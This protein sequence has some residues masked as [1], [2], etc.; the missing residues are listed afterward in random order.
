MEGQAEAP[1]SL[2]EGAPHV[3]RIVRVLEAQ[4]EVVR[5]SDE[6]TTRPKLRTHLALEPHVE[7]MVQVHVPEQRRQARPLGRSLRR[8][9]HALSVEDAD[10]QALPDEPHQRR[11]LSPVRLDRDAIDP[12]RGVPPQGSKRTF[13]RRLVDE[14]S[15]RED[16][17]FRMSF[18][19]LR[20]LHESR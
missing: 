11:E 15:Q 16:A 18:R 13:E 4:H 7:D 10:M 1:E 3:R 14:V 17:L 2:R 9:E 5:I 6:C 19:S 12:Y 8:F 20:Y